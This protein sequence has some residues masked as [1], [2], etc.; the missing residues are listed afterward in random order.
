LE[1]ARPCLHLWGFVTTPTGTQP[2][3]VT[4]SSIGLSW[5]PSTDNTAVTGYTIYRGGTPIATTTTTA[6]TDTAVAPNTTYTYALDAFDAAGNHSGQSPGLQVSTPAVSS[7]LPRFIQGAAIATGTRVTSASVAMP[8]AVGKGDLLVGW[9]AQYN[10]ASLLVVSDN[11]NGLW[12]RAPA[13]TAFQNDTGDIALY[14]LAN[15]KAVSAGGLTVTVSAGAAAYLQAAVDEYSGVAVAGPLDQAVANRGV[16]TSV[17]SGATKAV[18]AGELVFSGFVTGTNPGAV[19]PGSSQGVTYSPRARTTSGSAYS[20][21]VLSSAPGAQT[22]TANLTTSTDWYTVAAV[23]RPL[24]LGDDQPPNT[25]A[26]LHATGVS[27]SNVNL[28]WSAASDNV[29]TTGYTVYRNGSPVGTTAASATTFTDTSVTRGTAYTYTVDA[30]DGSGNHSAPSSGLQVNVPMSSPAFVQGAADSPGARKT[31]TTLTLTRPVVQ[32]DLLVGWF[33][34]YD[35][36]GQVHVSDPVNGAWTRSTAETFNGGTGD[37][38]IYYVQNTKAAAAGLVV[39]ISSSGATYLPSAISEY[40]GVATSGALDQTA[41]SKGVGLS[42]D[43]GPTSV[44]AG[45][46]LVFGAL[47]TGGQP[48]SVTPGSSQGVPFITNAFNGSRSAD[49]QA[50]YVGEAGA[51]NAR[52]VLGQNMDWYAAVATFR[53]AP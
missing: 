21:D 41:V 51:Q 40:S 22:G 19:T 12:T 28:A 18:G 27:S 30:F 16:G 42:A 2:T 25:P 4:T 11:V 5:S 23:F 43:S 45:G 6:Y 10:D 50:I 33:A 14:Y 8:G 47:I 36:P 7:A 44:V 29:G 1:P 20:Q 48:L 13:N 31:S 17:T 34:Q 39:T 37:L 35:S 38:A 26:S 53:P 24:P 9:F 52:F 49:T 15:S 3:T 46:E 32:G